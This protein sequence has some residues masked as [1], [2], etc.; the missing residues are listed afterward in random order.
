MRTQPKLG[1]NYIECVLSPDFLTDDPPCS[2]NSALYLISCMQYI[3]TCLCF[4]I[5]KPFRKPIYT[6]PVYLVSVVLMIVLQVYLTLFFDNSTGGWFGLV[7]LP[8]EFRYFL[9]GL[10]VINAGLSYGFE[11]F[12]IGWYSRQWNKK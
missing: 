3:T 12:F 4:S 2:D 11:K 8:T 1:D 6:N 9:F 5:S 10:I 7:N